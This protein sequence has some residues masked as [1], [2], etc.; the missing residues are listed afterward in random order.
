MS[1]SD[2]WRAVQALGEADG[3][4]ALV[5]RLRQRSGAATVERRPAARLPL[6][7]GLVVRRLLQVQHQA[8]A[9]TRLGDVHRAQ[10]AL[11]D[12]DAGLA[13]WRW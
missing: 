7:L 3:S 4:P 1:F 8:R 2:S 6:Q 11:V 12:L 5:P 9:L 10:V 13:R